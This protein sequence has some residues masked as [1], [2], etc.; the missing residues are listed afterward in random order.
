MGER[1]MFLNNNNFI[2]NINV[3]KPLIH[4]ITNYVTINDCANI[5]L[6]C[7]ASPIMAD[8]QME[9][10]EVTSISDALVINTGTLH[11]KTIE[12][13][14]KAGKRANQLNKPIILDPVGIGVSKFRMETIKNLLNEIHFTV[15]RGNI[16]EIKSIDRG[17]GLSKGV[18][19]LASDEI[20]VNNLEET[21]DFA[22]LISKK[23]GA[24]LVITGAYDII[25]NGN[26]AYVVQN[27]HPMMSKISGTGCMLT[28]LIGAFCGASTDCYLEAYLEATVA[29]VCTMGFCGELAYQRMVKDDGGTASLKVHLIDFIS[30]ITDESLKRGARYEIR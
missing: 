8:D 25:T 23:T 14:L 17:T 19:V 27:G 12:S 1:D 22:R 5:L 9:V 15:I 30:K 2:H 6:A 16:S 29:G 20:T 7:G 3:K 11:E 21:I 4:N 18:D 26:I 24:I 28:A 13:M 10:E